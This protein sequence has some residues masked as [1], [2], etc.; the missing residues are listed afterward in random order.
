M[1]N[2]R[3]LS[4]STVVVLLSCVCVF[5]FVLLCVPS[6]GLLSVSFLLCGCVCFASEAL[7]CTLDNEHFYL[8]DTRIFFRPARRDGCGCVCMCAAQLLDQ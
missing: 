5:S 6:L 4:C 7:V 2:L 1:F 3:F 8:G